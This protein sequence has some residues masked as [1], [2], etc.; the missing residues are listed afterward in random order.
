[1]EDKTGWE[2]YQYNGK[3]KTLP[4]F[5]DSLEKAK[6]PK[7]ILLY[8]KDFIQ[9][10]DEFKGMYRKIT[11][12]GGLVFNPQNEILFIYRRGYWDLPKGKM[13]K[14]E[15]KRQCALREVEEET[16]LKGLTINKK[17]TKTRHT[18][19]HPRTGQRMLKITHWYEMHTTGDYQDLSLQAEEDIEDAKWV[20]LNDFFDENNITFA[21]IRYLLNEYLMFQNS[22]KG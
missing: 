12:G 5:I 9:L 14:D 11:A 22:V 13:E 17:I 21:S 8:Y 19:R 2:C 20:T 18:Y 16:G 15:N 1:M 6:Q 3:V 10:K 4:N 7:K